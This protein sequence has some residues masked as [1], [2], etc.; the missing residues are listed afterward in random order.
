MSLVSRGVRNL[1]RNKART[2][3]VIL[4]VGFAIAIFL[5]AS[6]VSSSI[7]TN[8]FKLSASLDTTITVRPAGTSNFGMMGQSQETMNDSILS[9][10]WSVSHVSTV[11]PVISKMEN[12]QSS[13][14]SGPGFA[15]GRMVQ[16]MDPSQPI[17]LTF[18]GTPTISSGRALTSNDT[19]AYV[20]VIGKE[21]ANTSGLS[22]GS[23]ISLNGSALTVVGVYTSGTQ[24]GDR[25]IIIPYE[26]AKAV[27]NLTGMN[28]VYVTV[29]LVGSMDQAVQDLKSV[30]G[31]SY[32]VSALSSTTGDRAGQMQSSI[33]ATVSSSNFGKWASLLTAGAVMAFVMVLVI[34]ERTKEIGIMKALGFKDWKIASQLVIESIALALIGFAVGVI[35]AQVGAP[36]FASMFIG[37]R[38]TTD[39][40][41]P[42]GGL[43]APTMNFN[44]SLSSG[45]VASSLLLAVVLGVVG[46]LYPIITALR[47][48]PAEALRH[49]H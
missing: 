38:S 30:L 15:R 24:F 29:D 2:A 4:I 6:M 37:S 5:S 25:T 39:T 20:T 43:I 36:Y 23:A 14:T 1:F 9:Q 21:Y 12:D 32:D 27:Y 42:S 46:A 26:T 49:D 10:I 7:S 41:G 16:G 18:G 45:L 31:S 19:R 35:I 34:R 44:T 33:D 22:V 28:T 13:N 8:M 40:N 17:F 48:K 47:L 3:V 11:D